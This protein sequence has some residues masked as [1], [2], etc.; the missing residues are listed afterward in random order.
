MAIHSMVC[1]LWKPVLKSNNNW[2]SAKVYC[3]NSTLGGYSDWRLPNVD[4]LL[5][6]TIP[7]RGM[8]NINNVVNP[9]IVDIFQQNS[10]DHYGT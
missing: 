6:I 7:D 10:N 3:S 9:V 1:F 4:E 5:S 2:D 8:K